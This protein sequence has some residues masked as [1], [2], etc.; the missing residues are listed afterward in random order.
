MSATGASAVLERFRSQLG[1][2]AAS[3][4]GLRIRGGGSKDFYGERSTGDLLDTR[5][6]AGIVDYEPSELVVTARCGT[7]LAELERLLDGQGQMLG[8]EPP[9]FGGRATLGGAV[10]A[11]LSGPR[12]VASG[13]ARDFV[14]G[15][16]VLDGGGRDL[17]F[18]GRVM[19]NVAGYDVSRLMAGSL[20][21]LGLILEVSLKTL[22]KPVREESV[23]LELTWTEALALLK[24]SAGRL[25]LSASAWHDGSLFLRLSGSEPGVR[26]ALLTLGGDRL[27]E[28]DSFWPALRDQTHAFFS[29]ERPLWRIALA[30]T[31]SND[32]L[33]SLAGDR[34]FEWH[35][36]LAWISSDEP[37][38][39]VR[40]KA[41]RAGAHAT[42]FRGSPSSEPVFPPLSPTLFRI[43]RELKSVF[44]PHRI[45][46]RGRLYRDL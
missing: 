20:G 15:C 1:A 44:D 31:A 14:L 21:T 6:Y 3:A 35:G 41:A 32:A 38:A 11:G 17:Q 22:P 36:A 5:G 37:A 28:P 23:R 34:L 40:E 4:T 9:H 26:S 18:G 46:N 45:L 2:A 19:K 39:A 33:D 13:S 8:F 25:P 12:R 24:R 10:A 43:H 27:P 30:L 16:R 42:L 7:P 29:R